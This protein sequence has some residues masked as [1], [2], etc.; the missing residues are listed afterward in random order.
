AGIALDR[1]GYIVVDEHYQTSAA[2]IF[3]VG[4]VIGGPQVTHTPWGDHRLLYD[5]L[6]GR[7]G[8]RRRHPPIPYTVLPDP[9]LARVGLNEG[10]AR[11]CGVPYEIAVM[12]FG[13]IARAIETGQ[14]DGIMKVL[15]D[16]ATE[17]ILGATLLGAEAGELLHVFIPVMQ[18]GVTAR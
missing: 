4:D 10:D 8:R 13:D 3:A 9:Q 2:G 18:A 17:R 11:A 5:H 1:R 15:I 6:L 7:G 16:P 12:P 14:T